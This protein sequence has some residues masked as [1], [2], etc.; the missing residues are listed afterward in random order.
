VQPTNL[1]QSA[2]DLLDNL[3]YTGVAIGLILDSAGIPIP[4]EVLLS[5][6]A[7]LAHRGRFNVFALIIIGTLAQTVGAVIAYYIGDKGGVL[8]IQRYGK[9]FLISQKDLQKTHRAFEKYGTVLALVGRCVPVIR[10]YIGFVAGIGEMTLR[11]FVL[12]SL[13]GSF[14]WTLLLVWLGYRVA[15]NVATIDAIMKPFTDIVLVLLV[16]GVAWF[17]YRRVTE[18]AK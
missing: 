7:I 8:L 9:Y 16:A 13:V 11:R 10:G 1:T 4:S 18:R 6:G 5:G 12:A 3:G 2:I 15:G 17:I 14:I